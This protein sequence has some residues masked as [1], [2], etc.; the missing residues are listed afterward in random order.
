MMDLWTDRNRAYI[1]AGASKNI[2]LFY[3]KCIE[4]GQIWRLVWLTGTL[5]ALVSNTLTVAD[6][7]DGLGS[8]SSFRWEQASQTITLIVHF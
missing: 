4:W 1:D 8:H 3:L 7:Q 5:A 6:Q 2:L